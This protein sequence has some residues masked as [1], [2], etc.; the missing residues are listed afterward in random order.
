MTLQFHQIV[1]ISTPNT[2]SQNQKASEIG[3]LIDV[4]S[5]ETSIDVHDFNVETVVLISFASYQV[6]GRVGLHQNL[7]VTIP[8][9]LGKSN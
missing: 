3:I 8:T 2:T 4:S 7:V 6:P 1:E 5:E 9:S